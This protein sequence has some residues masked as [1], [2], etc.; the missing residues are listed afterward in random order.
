MSQHTPGE[1]YEHDQPCTDSDHAE[2]TY[3]ECGHTPG[4]WKANSAQHRG[5][6]SIDNEQGSSEIARVGKRADARLIATAPE[7]YGLLKTFIERWEKE[8]IIR[9]RAVALLAKIDGSQP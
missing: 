7:M 5:D 2:M 1:N 6:Y 4:P 9:E 3:A 8:A